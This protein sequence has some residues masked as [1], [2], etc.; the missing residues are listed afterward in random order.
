MVDASD[1]ESVRA[2]FRLH[3]QEIMERFKAH[4][5]A[6]GKKN[7]TD[8]EYVIV[9]YLDNAKQ[10]PQTPVIL[11]NISVKFEVTGPFALQK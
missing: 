4:G 6:I 9:V 8:Q 5:V 2:Y 11:D 10:L 1:L 7:P 3:K